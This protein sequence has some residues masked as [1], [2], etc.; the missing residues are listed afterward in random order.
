MLQLISCL[1]RH[2]SSFALPAQQDLPSGLTMLTKLTLFEWFLFYKPHVVPLLPHCLQGVLHFV[3]PPFFTSFAWA[4]FR[5][6]VIVH[7]PTP[8]QKVPPELQTIELEIPPS[9]PPSPVIKTLF[10]PF[11]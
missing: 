9:R 1:M 10:W 6:Q 11:S 7:K 5:A 2:L 4:S 8:W 3:R